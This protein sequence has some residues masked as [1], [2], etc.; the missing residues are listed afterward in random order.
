MLLPRIPACVFCVLTALAIAPSV[1]LAA[2]PIDTTAPDP[3]GAHVRALTP[4]MKQVIELGRRRSATFRE[5]IDRLNG[6]DVIVYLEN[7]HE[8]P[9]GLDGRLTFMTTA[10]GV[11][12]LRAQVTSSLDDDD[13]IAVAGHELQ[14]AIEVAS[15]PEVR[16]VASLAVLYTQIGVPSASARHRYD[17]LEAQSTGRR[18]RAELG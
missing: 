12:Y 14:H 17:T 2:S 6:S 1:P 10:G 11:R 3:L 7:T 16:D 15:H 13:L 18:V 8:L 9:A 5:L 4:R